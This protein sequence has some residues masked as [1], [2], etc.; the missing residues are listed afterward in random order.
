MLQTGKMNAR[1]LEL[2]KQPKNIQK[3]D[4]QVL[5][6]EIHTFPYLQNVRAL[7][8]YGVHLY[9]A[10]NYQKEL[11]KTAAYT[12]DKKN[13]YHLI[14]GKSEKIAEKVS[15][16]ETKV[17]EEAKPQ[18]PVYTQKSGGFPLRRVAPE[19]LAS[20]DPQKYTEVKPQ[21]ETT[22]EPV[23]VDGERNRILFEGEE[24]FLNEDHK[25][26]IDIESSLESGNLVTETAAVSD[27]VLEKKS[28]VEPVVNSESLI[29]DEEVIE[30]SVENHLESQ[31]IENSSSQEPTAE[32]VSEN[33]AH[34]SFDQSEIKVSPQDNLE[35]AVEFIAED[36]AISF[37]EIEALEVISNGDA[38]EEIT[39]AK[40][41]EEAA[42]FTP[43]TIIEEDKIDSVGEIDLVEDESQLSF[44]GTDSFLP[45]IKIESSN[46]PQTSHPITSSISANKYEDEMRRL[47]EQVE[48]KMKESKKEE[49]E[50]EATQKEEDTLD[51]FEISFAETQSFEVE[52]SVE[53]ISKNEME[54]VENSTQ[55][56][57]SQESIQEDVEEP[58]SAWKPMSFETNALDSTI[59]KINTV[60]VKTI[61]Q[62]QIKSEPLAVEE[63]EEMIVEELPVE[64]K[65]EEITAN[66]DVEIIEENTV[67]EQETEVENGI[68]EVEK[69]EEKTP[70]FNVSFFGNNISTFIKEE[71]KE[72][73]KVDVQSENSVQ[74]E[75]SKEMSLDSNV[76]G[77][78]NTW[79]SWLKIDRPV[80]VDKNKIEVKVKAIDTFIETNPRISQLK[81][82]VTFVV[83]EKNDDISHLMT[84]TLAR[85]YTE[86]KLYTK[87]IQAYKVLIGKHPDKKAY[88]EEKIQEVK[89]LRGR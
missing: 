69:T 77:F 33:I 44:H 60:E 70:A 83:K 35:E 32:S 8:L 51:N 43:E 12:T 78:I 88:F 36:Q 65:T 42:D 85:L 48:Q 45:D 18:F 23:F 4:L 68:A 67:E 73:P 49:K 20:E 5:K 89:D 66:S 30:T 63:K 79:Q 2:L 26:K 24:N 56:I 46:V 55:E 34:V 1:V 21:Q 62:P 47:I 16:S 13:L 19:E 86:Q 84:E 3:E 72:E 87:A 52:T 64:E 6:D 37:Q 58:K 39:I 75:V 14:N 15:V 53:E 31:N 57:V 82:E 61:A 11:S 9:D 80:E 74:P 41:R 71:G 22:N 28:L 7:H 50:T 40:E 81:D 17:V 27:E 25:V 29:S 38:I 10:E 59:G 54:A 76:P